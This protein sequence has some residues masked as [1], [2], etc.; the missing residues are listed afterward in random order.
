F[1]GLSGRIRRIPGGF[2]VRRQRA[3][4]AGA[5]HPVPS[6][7]RAPFR[8][9]RTSQPS[10]VSRARQPTPEPH[11]SR[12][13]AAV[14][15]SR[16]LS[17]PRTAGAR[18]DRVLPFA[19]CPVPRT[20]SRP[21]VPPVRCR[22]RAV[23]PC[24]CRQ[25]FRHDQ[26]NRQQMGKSVRRKIIGKSLSLVMFKFMYIIPLFLFSS[27]GKNCWHIFYLRNFAPFS[28]FSGIFTPIL[29][30]FGICTLRPPQDCLL[31]IFLLTPI[32][33]WAVQR[34]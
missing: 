18:L 26:Q 17:R 4:G 29:F 5:V 30:C 1:L 2:G 25:S 6:A 16:P 13:N 14:W 31:Q 19:L 8:R 7:G 24:R 11:P 22:R 28:K 10:R 33:F 34:P 21:A 9:R 23:P 3:G 15:T 12:V 20:R 32:Q 27:T